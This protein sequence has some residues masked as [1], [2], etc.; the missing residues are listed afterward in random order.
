MRRIDTF[1]RYGFLPFS[2]HGALKAV[3]RMELVVY[4]APKFGSAM[5]P[6]PHPDEDAIVE[7]LRPVVSGGSTG[8]RSH[9]VITV[10]TIR[11]DSDFDAYLSLCAGGESRQADH[12]NRR[13]Q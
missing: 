12:G 13:Y 4:V 9:V 7:P 10:G 2:R 11:S 8:V 1:L 3:V 6:R 5:K